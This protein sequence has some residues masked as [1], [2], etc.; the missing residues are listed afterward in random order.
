MTV[1]K[2]LDLVAEAKTG[3]ENLDPQQV[4]AEASTDGVL[5]VDLREA[6]EREELGAIAGAIHAPRGLLEFYAD[7]TFPKYKPEFRADR[8]TILYCA[9][10][11][12]SALAAE[13]LARMGYTNVA[14]LDGGFAAWVEAGCAV[15]G[16]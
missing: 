5:L 8:R 13:T 16:S 1:T 10:G 2:A 4:E 6:S 7:P 11:G 14:H 3:I 15:D 9:S 12:R